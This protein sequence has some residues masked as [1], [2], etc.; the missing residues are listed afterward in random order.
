MPIPHDLPGNLIVAA[1]DS[2][3]PDKSRWPK[4]R[5]SRQFDVIHP[6]PGKRWPLPPKLVLSE[7]WRIATGKPL[8][9]D[10]FNSHRANAHLAGC[11]FRIVT[12]TGCDAPPEAYR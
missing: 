3:G 1:M 12:K 5:H 4:S 9:S 8:S 10:E 6:D 7:A 2:L 11:G